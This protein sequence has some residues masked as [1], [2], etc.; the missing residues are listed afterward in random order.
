MSTQDSG[1][2]STVKTPKLSAVLWFVI[3]VVAL[4]VLAKFVLSARGPDEAALS[5]EAV[6]ARI[7]PVANVTIF[8]AGGGSART[9]E[10]IVKTACFVCHGAGVAG[11]PKIGDKAAW[12]PLLKTGL[13]GLLKSSIKGK[14]AMPPRGGLPDLSDY[15]L[16]R[17]IVNIANKSG[18]SFKEPAAPVAKPQAAAK[19]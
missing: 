8:E 18:A 11:A 1:H 2:G 10:E 12:A 7:K 19:K 3:A 16:A 9:G 6:W 13:D 4:I 14:G 15:E 17:A 5:P